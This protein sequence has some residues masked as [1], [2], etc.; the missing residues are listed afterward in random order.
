MLPQYYTRLADFDISG[1]SLLVKAP[2]DS[3]LI[4][5]YFYL[6]STEE[7]D[8]KHYCNHSGVVISLRIAPL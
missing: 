8:M 6:A 2:T 3:R 4:K 1:H 5:L 7:N